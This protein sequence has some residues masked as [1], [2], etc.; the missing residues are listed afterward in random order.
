MSRSKTSA[1][2]GRK[3]YAGGD[4][5]VKSCIPKARA[6]PK[7]GAGSLE[8]DATAGKLPDACA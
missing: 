3:P 5:P 6:A 1:E 8:A 4:C 2:A 7:R